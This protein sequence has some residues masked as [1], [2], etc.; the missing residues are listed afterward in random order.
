M[1]MQ[2]NRLLIG[3]LLATATTAAFA[4]DPAPATAPPPPSMDDP[5]Q[6]ATAESIKPNDPRLAPL[7]AES[8]PA[9]STKKAATEDSAAANE[10]M[11]SDG[12]PSNLPK[13]PTD[14]AFHPPPKQS[15]QNN[16]VDGYSVHTYTEGN[17]DRIEEYR[18]GGQLTKV[19]VQPAHGKAFELNDSNG[20]GRINRSD[21]TNN[22]VEPVQ[23]KL[24]E[25]H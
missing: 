11:K 3:L 16:S 7:P 4:A 20:D 23:W 22:Q 9:Q 15:D 12:D 14:D 19:R 10:H 5:G 2:C 13:L 8:A 17:G 25:W 18:H 1:R 24:F 6:P 21:V